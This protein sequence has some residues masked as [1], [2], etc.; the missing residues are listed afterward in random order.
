VPSP[1]KL[2]RLNDLEFEKYFVAPMIDVTEAGD[3]AM[4][5]WPYVDRVLADEFD[6]AASGEINVKWV[7]RTGDGAFD[8][9]IIP[10]VSDDVPLVVVVDRGSGQ[11]VGRH[12]LN[13]RMKY[14]L[15]H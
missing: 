1:R 13:L 5:I 2:N 9:V 6:D 3:A 11:I 12:H 4:D 7:Y 14:G 10:I 8:H 15:A